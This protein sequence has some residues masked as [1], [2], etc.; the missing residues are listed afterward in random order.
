MYN[1]VRYISDQSASNFAQNIDTSNF[2]IFT[3]KCYSKCLTLMYFVRNEEYG[4]IK[5]WYQQ[6]S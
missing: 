6:S 2:E 1:N 3:S 5:N 4:K